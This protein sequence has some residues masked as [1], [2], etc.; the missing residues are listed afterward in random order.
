MKNPIGGKFLSLIFASSLLIASSC[1]KD[2]EV[3]PAE[4]KGK[5]SANFNSALTYGTV[6]DEEG[7]VYKTIKIGTQTWMA[8][9]LRTTHYQNGDPIPNV[10][11]TAEWL[12]LTTGAYC[13]YG[14]SNNLDSIAT[15]GR[16][17]NWYVAGD[18]RK[19]CPKGWHIPSNA[20]RNALMSQ[21]GPDKQGGKLKE[22]G[23]SHWA[24]N[25]NGSNN[26]GF[27]ALPSGLRGGDKG[28][29]F[30]LGHL[31]EWWLSDEKDANNAWY[32]DV[33]DNYD[34]SYHGSGFKRAGYCIRCM[35]D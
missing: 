4:V 10:K 5:S 33:G 27:T 30:N 12:K 8:E 7:N 6:R 25:T 17:Y 28:D 9:N 2:D 26:S 31:T 18:S 13:T 15:F 20:E 29:F 16:L 32:F 19:I 35:Q 23:L 11:G 3:T 14:N 34:Y 1:K 22:G 24:L 21:L